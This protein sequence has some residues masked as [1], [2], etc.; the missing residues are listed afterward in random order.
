M[1]KDKE[2]G[3]AASNYRPTTCLPLVQK[4]LKNLLNSRKTR[5]ANDLLLIDKMIMREVEINQRNLSMAC[6]DHKKT[7]K[8]GA[9]LVDK[10]LFGNR[11]NK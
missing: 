2:K 3:K 9:L 6:V 8:Y 11:R 5:G 7:Y 4:L 1:Q 10:R